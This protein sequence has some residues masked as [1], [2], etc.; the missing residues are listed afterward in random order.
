MIISPSRVCPR[1]PPFHPRLSGWAGRA[2]DNF[3]VQASLA[4]SSG[5]DRPVVMRIKGRPPGGPTRTKLGTDSRAALARILSDTPP[6]PSGFGGQVMPLSPHEEQLLA[7]FSHTDM[8]RIINRRSQQEAELRAVKMAVKLG[9]D[10]AA[11]C[12]G[13]ILERT[14]G[15][16]NTIEA[17]LV[18]EAPRVPSPPRPSQ[19]SPDGTRSQSP[20]TPTAGGGRDGGH[21]GSAAE[22]PRGSQAP[23]L[24]PWTEAP[25]GDDYWWGSGGAE[26]AAEPAE[27]M[28]LRR[29]LDRPEAQHEW[30]H[31]SV[32]QIAAMMKRVPFF[33]E[34]E[35]PPECYAQV[36]SWFELCYF[37]RYRLLAA[38]G[39]ACHAF[40]ILAHGTAE[41]IE[42]TAV[43]A[44]A[45]AAAATDAPA[46]G[47][48]APSSGVGTGGGGGS[49]DGAAEGDEHL[50]RRAPRGT[51][52]GAGAHWGASALSGAELPHACSVRALDPCVV[53]TLRTH[54]IRQEV[55]SLP[56]L[57]AQAW[58]AEAAR[59]R[60]AH[61]YAAR[62]WR[63]RA[64]RGLLSAARPSLSAALIDELEEL[65]EYRLLPRG[66][67][68]L[69]HGQHAEAL[70]LLLRGEV[71]LYAP[72]ASASASAAAAS[73]ASDAPPAAASA[74]LGAAS[75][76]GCGGADDDA[77]STS[78]ETSRRSTPRQTP[79]QT[80]R[81]CSCTATPR[82]ATPRTPRT[83]GGGGDADP[84]ADGGG[85]GP[86]GARSQMYRVRQ[87]DASATKAAA[88]VAAAAKANSAFALGGAADG[89]LVGRVGASSDPIKKLLG[90]EALEGRRARATAV[91]VASMSQVFTVPLHS[92][93]A[94]TALS[95]ALLGWAHH[96]GPRFHGLLAQ[97]RPDRFVPPPRD[98]PSLWPSA[99]RKVSL[100][101]MLQPQSP[102]S[103]SSTLVG[104]C[105][106][107]GATDALPPPPQQQQQQQQQQPA[108]A[109][110]RLSGTW[111]DA[112]GETGAPAAN[113]PP[114]HGRRAVAAALLTAAPAAAHVAV[115]A[116]AAAD[117]GG[118]A[119]EEDA[120]LRARARAAAD[121]ARAARA[122]AQPLHEDGGGD[123]DDDEEAR[124]AALYDSSG[125]AS[126]SL[127]RRMSGRS[128]WADGI[129]RG[130]ST[131]GDFAALPARHQSQGSGSSSRRSSA[132]PPGSIYD[133]AERRDAEERR[134]A[135]RDALPLTRRASCVQAPLWHT[136]HSIVAAELATHQ[137]ARVAAEAHAQQPRGNEY[138]G[139]GWSTG[140]SC[141]SSMR[142]S[143]GAGGW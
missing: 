116:A 54:R 66:T 5:S 56:Y 40:C 95:Q 12:L 123:D 113:Q 96:E 117:D 24:R 125:R 110:A 44:A 17:G 43:A 75:A 136:T 133:E 18:K 27:G 131:L 89:G 13:N 134:A 141:K 4:S 3:S 29:L 36:A 84:T 67:A 86:R 130:R 19:L 126:F 120:E 82:A 62:E 50:W 74:G 79:R 101:Q 45:A 137:G 88:S 81:S 23:G 61:A 127:G 70:H 135:Q 10:R 118:G 26:E 58:Q 39:S 132:A 9:P 105:T 53:L 78:A 42:A 60:I 106:A 112:A 85:G 38:E 129:E 47:G 139:S 7:V 119:E 65:C 83:P 111:S 72:D 97:L 94:K 102:T 14:M 35:L 124:I 142:S 122:S 121:K 98:S 51:I 93:R 33:R 49:A 76:A 2:R 32:A 69:Q 73:A 6:G 28:S 108:T 30:P 100:V 34:A 48:A 20:R 11:E 1:L 68:L 103:R 8:G 140:A 15:R 92:L 46:T 41:A 107:R 128:V 104:A 55:A 143:F 87:Q 114:L 57:A 31:V 90:A 71:A 25:R 21:A 64:L 115:A 52:L 63:R 16:I 59:G 138:G 99:V 77:P 37:E 80:P 109:R 91:T 22:S